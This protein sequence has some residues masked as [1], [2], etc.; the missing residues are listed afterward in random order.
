[1]KRIAELLPQTWKNA[2]A[3]APECDRQP[4]L[5]RSP[6]SLSDSSCPVYPISPAAS[7]YQRRVERLRVLNRWEKSGWAAARSRQVLAKESQKGSNFAIWTCFWLKA[8]NSTAI[9]PTSSRVRG[10]SGRKHTKI[11]RRAEVLPT[12]SLIP[13]SCLRARSAPALRAGRVV[14]PPPLPALRPSLRSPSA[15]GLVFKGLNCGPGGSRRC[16]AG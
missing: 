11:G 6:S 4:R 8:S 9:P 2:R 16:G 1:M 3:I 10:G 5:F 14:V 12:V 13:A 7:R 15:S